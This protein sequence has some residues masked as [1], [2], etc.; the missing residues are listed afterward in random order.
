MN[1]QNNAE[2]QNSDS[3]DLFKLINTSK[4]GNLNF[5]LKRHLNSISNPLS[6]NYC[7]A[8]NCCA[9]N[10]KLLTFKYSVLV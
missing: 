1:C 10:K 8:N 3:K 4:L 7:S 6:N 2:N 5:L 9:A